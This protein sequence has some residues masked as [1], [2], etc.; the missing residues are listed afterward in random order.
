MLI[1]T[2][3]ES[4]F[5]ISAAQIAAKFFKKNA[6]EYLKEFTIKEKEYDELNTLLQEQNIGELCCLEKYFED[7]EE[8]N[9]LKEKARKLNE[10]EEA[11]L[12]ADSLPKKERDYL[13]VLLWNHGPVG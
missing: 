3:I 4:Q 10:L 8:D 5:P 6:K 11:H 12:W 7:T 2:R 13:E 9:L 1:K